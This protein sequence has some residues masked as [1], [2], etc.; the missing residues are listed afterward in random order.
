MSYN[1]LKQ[2]ISAQEKHGKMKE[3]SG[4]TGRSAYWRDETK[5]SCKYAVLWGAYLDKSASQPPITSSEEVWILPLILRDRPRFPMNPAPLMHRH[6]QRN[7]WQSHMLSEIGMV[8]TMRHVLGRL[9][10]WL[11]HVEG[12]RGLPNLSDSW[13]WLLG[14]VKPKMHLSHKTIVSMWLVCHPFLR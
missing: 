4:G 9:N 6:Q 1:L 11:M 7:Q 8:G 2:R 5:Q 3:T 14:L 12:H 10:M 13:G